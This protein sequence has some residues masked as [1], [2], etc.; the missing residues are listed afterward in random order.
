MLGWNN[1]VLFRQVSQLLQKMKT[2]S[3]KMYEDSENFILG[4][5]N[6]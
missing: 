3:C 6:K 1:L 4:L 2:L 5:G